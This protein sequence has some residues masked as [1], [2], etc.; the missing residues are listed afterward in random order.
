[1]RT[2]PKSSEK[3]TSLYEQIVTHLNKSL[4]IQ[5]KMLFVRTNRNF[6]EQ[7]I[8]SSEQIANSVEEILIRQN[9]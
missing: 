7:I 2:N 6:S 5:T 9:K 1:M 8:Y 4:F 3:I